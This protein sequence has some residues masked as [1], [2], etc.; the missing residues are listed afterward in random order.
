MSMILYVPNNM[1][2]YQLTHI[3]NKDISL[4]PLQ[5]AQYLQIKI[6][7]AMKQLTQGWILERYA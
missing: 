4:R 7:H 1:H 2:S 3:C 5:E 6:F